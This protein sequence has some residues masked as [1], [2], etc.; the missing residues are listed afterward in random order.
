MQNKVDSAGSLEAAKK[1]ITE[2]INKSSAFVVITVGDE[3][4][5]STSYQMYGD[6]GKLI[7]SCKSAMHADDQIKMFFTRAVLEEATDAND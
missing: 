3:S 4:S 7:E 1:S 2:L 5:F 6:T